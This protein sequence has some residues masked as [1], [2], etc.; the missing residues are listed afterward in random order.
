MYIGK[1]TKGYMFRLNKLAIIRSN[2]KNKAGEIPSQGTNTFYEE[3]AQCLKC[4]KTSGGIKTLE[5]K[6]NWNSLV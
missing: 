6:K 4:I 3:C 5:E 1:D 2:Y